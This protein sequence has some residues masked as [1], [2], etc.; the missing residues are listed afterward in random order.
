[1]FWRGHIPHREIR[2]SVSKRTTPHLES[3]TRARRRQQ[4]ICSRL[5]PVGNA[6]AT[7][8][9]PRVRYLYHQQHR[10][11]DRRGR[12]RSSIVDASSR[13]LPTSS[14]ISRRAASDRAEAQRGR[15]GQPPLSSAHSRGSFMYALFTK[16]KQRLERYSCRQTCR[17]MTIT[18]FKRCNYTNLPSLHYLYSSTLHNR[19]QCYCRFTAGLSGMTKIHLQCGR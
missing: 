14:N 18:R 10:N 1:M 17:R 6:A 16:M 8:R 9:G 12:L 13:P 19:L 2:G 5:R 7:P 4:H 11:S 3:I 15:G